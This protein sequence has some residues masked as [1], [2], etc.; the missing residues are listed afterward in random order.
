MDVMKDSFCEFPSDSNERT[1][2]NSTEPKQES[3]DEIDEPM[4]LLRV[5]SVTVKGLGLVHNYVPVREEDAGKRCMVDG[6]PETSTLRFVGLYAASHNDHNRYMNRA[7]LGVWCK[8]KIQ[9]EKTK[10]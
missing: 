5:G 1:P 6:F 4:P 2:V 7:M 10:S 3:D 8:L 9:T